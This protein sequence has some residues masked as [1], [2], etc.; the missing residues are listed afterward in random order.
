MNKGICFYRLF[1]LFLIGILLLSGCTGSR[2]AEFPFISLSQNQEQTV[3][4]PLDKDAFTIAIAGPTSA[5]FASLY[6]EDLTNYLAKAL[7]SRVQLVFRKTYAEVNDL[8]RAGT[9]QLGIVSSCSY[10]FGKEDFGLE[11][12]VTPV[13]NEGETL[14]SY[15]L[16]HRDSDIYTMIDLENRTFAFTDPDSTLGSIYPKYLLLQNGHVAEDFFSSHIYTYSTDNSIRAVSN[17]LVDGAAANNMALAR[18]SA[19]EHHITDV[20][21]I[22]H[23]SPPLPMNPIVISPN[24]SPAEKENLAEIFLTMKE[25]ESG[26]AVLTGLGYSHFTTADCSQYDSVCSMIQASGRRDVE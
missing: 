21:R 10:L 23:A 20:I 15:I 9:V 2:D 12:L 18:L 11:M 4:K 3:V 1:F 26:A 22:I 25:D 24:V 16:V 17:K 13:L 7:D 14:N 8:L 6:Y 19:K 5:Q